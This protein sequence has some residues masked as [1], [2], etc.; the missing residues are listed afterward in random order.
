[1]LKYE[2]GEYY[3]THHDYNEHQLERQS[4]V[5]I[6]TV[7]MYLNDL[8]EGDGGGT[9]FTSLGLTVQPKRG[10]AVIWPS[11]KNESPHE[12]DPRTMHQALPVKNGAV[13]YGSNAWIHQRDFKT[14]H[15]NGCT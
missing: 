8:E 6:L 11:V 2:E 3:Q 10:R 13:K 12:K 5:R 14:A 9:Q 15:K 1:M 4:G 7:Y